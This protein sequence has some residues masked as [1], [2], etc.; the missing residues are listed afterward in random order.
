MAAILERDPICHGG[1]RHLARRWMLLLLLVCLPVLASAQDWNYRIRPGDTL[2]GLAG[3][4]L[5][6]GI[7]W[8]RL[9]A[10]NDI[11]NPYHLPPGTTL[12]FPL[13]WLH[14]QPALAKVVAVRGEASV[15]GVGNAGPIIEGMQLGIGALLRTSRDATLSLQFADGSR[16]LLMGDSELR[17][18]R[19]S[20]YGKSGMVDTRLRLQRGRITNDV[21]PTRGAAPAFIVDTPNASSAVRGTRFRVNT[22]ATDRTQAEVTEGTVA[23]SAK[24]GNTLVRKNYGAVV[25]QHQAGGI[26]AVALL[27]APDL[28]GATPLYSGAR[29]RFE[30]PALTG[31]RQYRVQVSN[32]PTFDTLV[33]DTETTEPEIT[34]PQLQEGEYS[35]RI[36]G[37][38]GAGL[39]GRD[40]ITRFTAEAFLEAPIG[41]SP[42]D[43]STVREQKPEF[44]WAGIADAAQYRFQLSAD[45]SFQTTVLALEEKSTALRVSQPLPP[46][47]YFW[48]VATEA[49]NGRVGPYSDP[50][51]FTLRSLQESGPL[52]SEVDKREITFRWRKGAE[53]Q[54]YRFQLSRSPD[55]HKTRVDQIVTDAQITLPKL[56]AGTWYL[57]AQAI[58]EDGFEGPLP[59]AQSVKIPCAICK[60]V[61]GG[62]L[63][64]LLLAL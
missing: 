41:I 54:R 34:L 2:W 20:R 19:M 56:P 47:H 26:R 15:S 10:H 6:P 3:E 45:A 28:H 55:F 32:S 35:L 16:L 48:R 57:R 17:L 60:A 4:Y 18:D 5:K 23:V 9:Q 31:A 61:A 14:L 59:P 25:S 51:T 8:Q 40:S 53:G 30:W 43:N 24:S 27:P 52:E 7:P 42:S 44:R 12:H 29:A 64:W 22:T 11:A 50:T 63:L 62:G 36:R 46:G 33:V 37:I 58:G 39:E 21:V 49:G 1:T 13:A 38:D